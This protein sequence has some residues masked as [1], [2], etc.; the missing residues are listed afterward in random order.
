MTEQGNL[1]KKQLNVV[2]VF[3]ITAGSMIS[4]G[5]FILPAI[6]YLKAGN[7]IILAYLLA[8]ILAIPALIA[9]LE[10]ATAMP[11]SGGTY[12]FI[13]RSMGPLFGTFSGLTAW[14]SLALKSAFA[15]YG[16]ALVIYDFAVSL[17][18]P[19][20]Q[21][22]IPLIAAVTTFILGIVNALGSRKSG[23]LQI[24][25]VMVL[26]AILFLFVILV[27]PKINIVN[28]VQGE[29]NFRSI[30]MVTSMIFISFGGLTKTAS[31]A[32]EVENPGRSLK[33]GMVGAFAVV[34][35]LY[36]L[37][38]TATI[39][40]LS[41]A[42]LTTT[43]Q[44]LALAAS[45][46][47]GIVAE[48]ILQF[49]SILAFL[50]T[51]N[52]GLMAAS[53]TPLAMG[54]DRLLPA[55]LAHINIK[56]HTPVRAIFLTAGFMILVLM[57]LN[58]EQL[59]KAAS[60][61]KLILFAFAILSLI[62]MRESKIV[63]YR[64]IYR[65][66]LYPVVHIL[67]ILAYLLLLLTMGTT[68]LIIT[69]GFA[70]IALLWYLFFARKLPEKDS[71]IIQLVKRISHKKLESH[72]LND[73]LRDILFE[74]EDITED[75][76][77]LLVKNAPVLDIS[78]SM[79]KD[80]L[81][82][83]VGELLS[84]RLELPPE[85]ITHLLRERESASSTAISPG[86]AIPHLIIPGEKHFDML[87]CRS[88]EGINFGEETAPVHICFVLAGTSDERSFHL[89]TLVAIAQI[90]QSGD[91]QKSWGKVRGEDD[92][93]DLILLAERAR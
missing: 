83:R 72:R 27:I 69:A 84:S 73:E 28:I 35:V 54:R 79:D 8:A 1:G 67:G 2:H 60:A 43:N 31:L 23:S 12:F 42:E 86:L 49:A 56:S 74:R 9:K 5:L 81:F 80:E 22:I 93:R 14:F 16:L 76:F 63:G 17:L 19:L 34:S 46:G 88:N 10:L 62:I 21:I 36:L 89:K 58:L 29:S 20:P 90:V 40:V 70:L 7:G 51:G 75:R 82:T 33:I 65:S 39:G 41:P 26:L 91:F 59:V 6:V 47:I 55:G 87:I 61:M 53:R 37:S 52:A 30:W 57:T 11:R 64:P 32:E 13:H 78:G 50:T 44:P 24:V 15:L 4:S 77:D 48:R 92:L 71:A 85:E 3:S 68:P 66:K 38:V 45:R 25:M 18:G